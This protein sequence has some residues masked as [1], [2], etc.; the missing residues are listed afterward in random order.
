M[1]SRAISAVVKAIPEALSI[2]Y[3]N[4]V[5]ELQRKGKDVIVLSL[6]ESFFDIPHFSF[7]G[8]DYEKGLHYSHSRGIL[9]LRKMISTFYKKRYGV[10]S[11]PESEVI[12]SAGSK[13]LIYMAL[14]TIISPGDQVIILEPAWVSYTEQVRLSHGVPVMVPYYERIADIGKYRTR[15]TK[16][17]IVNNPNNPSGKVYSKKEL[18]H[19]Y[20]FA[21]K[22]NLYI[23]SDEPY[24]DFVKEEPFYSMG[25]FDPKKQRVIIANSL[26][27]NMGM[28]GLRI[29]YC[30]AN[31]EIINMIL[32]LNQ[33][34]ITCPATMIELYVIKYLDKIL[35]ITFPQI[36][37]LMLKRR[38]I[39][40]YMDSIGLS[41]L[42]GT[43]TFYFTVSIQPSRLSSDDFA[44]KLLKEYFVAT[45]PGIGY[46]ESL[47]AYL[48]VG[49]GT[50]SV[51][52]IKR[53]L[54]AIR[55]LIEKTRS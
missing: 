6:G 34:I 54:L 18:Q 52:R 39:T 2:K 50:E 44:R 22:H 49:I 16:A 55:T 20:R 5:Y 42:P 47:D 32:K 25:R 33:H 30:I 53:G 41:A 36:K 26:S 29:G 3:N 10:A 46:G 48:R 13:A 35:K 43:G 1:K 31:K 7:T 4:L 11:D 40:R 15:R 45:V 37:K 27:K 21:E 51:P 12:V 19:I 38:E 23:L 24:S 9:E 8:L 17:I 28:S 14:Q